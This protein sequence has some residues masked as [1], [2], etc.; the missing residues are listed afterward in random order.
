MVPFI[1]PIIF[2]I[3]L[4]TGISVFIKLRFPVRYDSPDNILFSLPTISDD[5]GNC[6]P[7]TFQ[8]NL[9]VIHEDDWR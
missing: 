5:I 2:I 4:I 9:F 7:K 8:K 6:E 3:A 1:L